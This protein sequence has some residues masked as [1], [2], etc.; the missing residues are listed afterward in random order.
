MLPKY[1][2]LFRWPQ[3]FSK[4]LL[5]ISSTQKSIA[6]SLFWLWPIWLHRMI[7]RIWL[8]FFAKCIALHAEWPFCLIYTDEGKICSSK[9]YKGC[10]WS[11]WFKNIL[12]RNE[13]AQFHSNQFLWQEQTFSLYWTNQGNGIATGM[14]KGGTS[15]KLRA[16]NVE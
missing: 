7:V 8:P 1:N 4:V 3:W 9:P 11:W 6:I 16:I 2:Y 5:T 12:V 13:I 14:V 15:L 10:T